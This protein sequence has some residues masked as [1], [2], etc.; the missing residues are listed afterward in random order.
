M[1]H[2]LLVWALVGLVAGWLANIFFG[3]KGLI[4]N[5]VVG[6]VGSVVGGYLFAFVGID[7]PI[8]NMWIRD[9]LTA[10]VGAAIVIMIARIVA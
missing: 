10:A 7:L 4:R 3:G 1:L 9:I 6:M 2:A 5:L 8:A